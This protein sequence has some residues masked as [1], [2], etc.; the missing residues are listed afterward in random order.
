ML[1]ISSYEKKIA[2]L[3]EQLDLLKPFDIDQ[4][5]N[6]RERFR[7]WFIHHSN[8]IEGNTLTLQEVKMV[9]EEGMTIGGKTVRELRETINHGDLMEVL[10]DF[11]VKNKLTLTETFVCK[12]HKLL[13]EWLVEKK[14]LGSYRDINIYVS[15][16]EEKFP[17]PKKISAL[18][19]KFF[20][21]YAQIKSLKDVAKLHYDFVKIHPFVDG[22]GRL[23]RIL[24]NLGLV[25][26][27]YLPIIIPKVVRSEYIASLQGKNFEKRHT[28]FLWQV[29]ENMKDYVRFLTK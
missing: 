21:D 15:W 5:K 17:E 23:A 8:A 27:W 16:T 2:E 25:S 26:L 4:L 13:L 9:V 24:M 22:N 14:H 28:F 18:M 3:K 6:L 7:I 20:A 12:L 11:F 19:K 10:E 29:C 1:S